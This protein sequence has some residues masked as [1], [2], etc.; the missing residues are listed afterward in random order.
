MPME[1]FHILGIY[2]LFAYIVFHLTGVLLVEFTE[3][4]GIISRIIS[5]SEDKD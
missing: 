5:G 4:K 3:Q 1:E 2:Y